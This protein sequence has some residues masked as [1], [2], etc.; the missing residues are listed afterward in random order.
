MSWLLTAWRS[1]I[2]GCN[3]HESPAAVTPVKQIGKYSCLVGES[4]GKKK[5]DRGVWNW[6][7]VVK[8]SHGNDLLHFY[9][10]KIIFFFIFFLHS[11]DIVYCIWAWSECISSDCLTVKY[12]VITVFRIRFVQ[13]IAQIMAHVGVDAYHSFAQKMAISKCTLLHYG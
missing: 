1:M 2:C 4:E 3:I 13:V 12:T 5:K 8:H 7:L 9:I 11:P 10:L 6:V